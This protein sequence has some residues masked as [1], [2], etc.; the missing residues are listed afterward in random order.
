ML[1]RPHT[2]NKAHGISA[3]TKHVELNHVSLLKS[4]KEIQHACPQIIRNWKLT[5]KWENM[6]PSSIF[7]F[8]SS[9]NSF[10][11]D[12]ETQKRFL[13][14]VMLFVIKVFFSINDSWI[15]LDAKISSSIVPKGELPIQECFHWWHSSYIVK[16]DLEKIC[17]T[18]LGRMHDYHMHFWPL[19]VKREPWRFC[20]G[21]EFSLCQLGA[22]TH[23]CW[24]VWGPW[25][26]WCYHG[27][28]VKTNPWQ[29]FTHIKD[30]D[31]HQGW[32]LQFEIVF[33]LSN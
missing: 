22:E 10:P 7:G 6:S 28:E 23:H 32:G 31:L 26:E 33:K 30:F 9:S 20:S 1:Q 27:Y 21:C 2:Y 12:H 13:E 19:D 18:C 5:T 4:F 24:V 17:V 14:D 11:K 25:Y 8:F 15:H 3:M 16:Q 29:I